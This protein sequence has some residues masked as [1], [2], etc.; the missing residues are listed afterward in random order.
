MAS[1]GK[2]DKD[3]LAGIAAEDAFIRHLC[4]AK[5]EFKRDFWTRHTGN[6]AIEFEKKSTNGSTEPSGLGVN[7]S[8]WYGFDFGHECRMTI[9]THIVKQL[10]KIAKQRGMTKWIGD[11]NRFHC[12]LIPVEWFTGYGPADEPEWRH[13]GNNAD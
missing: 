6:V 2:F 4:Q 5:I 9:P 7:D 12:A 10:T 13:P 8:Y 11:G 1:N 3:F